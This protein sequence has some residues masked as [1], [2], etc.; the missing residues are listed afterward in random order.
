VNSV[1]DR[2][3]LEFFR[4]G[5]RF[6]QVP[7]NSPEPVERALNAELNY[8]TDERKQ[9]IRR[10]LSKLK[11]KDRTVLE[12]VFLLEQDKDTICA[13]MKIDRNYLRVQVHRA[14][15]RFRKALEDGGDPPLAK[16]VSAR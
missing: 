11:S 3:V 8:I 1:S 2:V 5:N 6:Q 10:E 9:I 15:A 4:E 12:R 13:E 16:K 14:L 7:E